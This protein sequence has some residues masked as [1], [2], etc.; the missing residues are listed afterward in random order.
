MFFEELRDGATYRTASHTVTADELD[1]FARDFDPQPMHLDAEASVLLPFGGVIAS[2]FHTLA[3]AWRLWVEI[4]LDDHGRGGIAL[5]DV[6]WHR[7]VY[8]GT[9]VCS[10]VHIEGP[11]VTSQGKG[12]AT[13]RFEVLDGDDQ[14]LLTF[15]TTGLFA[16][17]SEGS[18][19]AP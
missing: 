3:L 12:L 19:T 8:A 4:G 5:G 18:P 7:P 1:G 17:R 14:L 11:R 13:M 2:G 10:V 16:R 6:R 15:A 9:E